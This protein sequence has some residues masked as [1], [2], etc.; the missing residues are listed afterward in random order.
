MDENTLKQM[1]D[2]LTSQGEEAPSVF[3][4][5]ARFVKDDYP[6]DKQGQLL[7]MAKARFAGGDVPSRLPVA[8]GVNLRWGLPDGSQQAWFL[9]VRDDDDPEGKAYFTIR[10]K[11]TFAGEL[12]AWCLHLQR[13]KVPDSQ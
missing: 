11:D 5:Y 7:E 8:P 13:I 1:L 12:A 10:I 9:T 2:Q 3:G 4:A 6:A